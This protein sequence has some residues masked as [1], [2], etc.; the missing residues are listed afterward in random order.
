MQGDVI[1]T[2]KKGERRNGNGSDGRLSERRAGTVRLTG[3]SILVCV[4]QHQAGGKKKG[5]NIIGNSRMVN[6]TTVSTSVQPGRL[7]GLLTTV[8]PAIITRIPAVKLDQISK[9]DWRE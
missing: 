8:A 2:V 5:E 7:P 9:H 4:S 1:C 6:R 3:A